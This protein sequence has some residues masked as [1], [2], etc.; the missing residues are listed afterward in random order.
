MH[1]TIECLRIIQ[2]IQSRHKEAFSSV[3]EP[4][5]MRDLLTPKQVAQA[6]GA[7]EAS[8]KR[9]CDKGLVPTLRTAG[10]HR[11]LPLDGVLQFLRES[12][13]PLVRPE[14]LGLPSA[15]GKG[16]F[17]LERAQA[18]LTSALVAGDE[19]QFSR[20]VFDLYVSGQT[21]AAIC[22]RAIAPAFAEIGERWD[23]G[24]VH[25]YEERR[26]CEVC[27]RV[28]HRLRAALPHPPPTAPSAIG[29]TLEADPYGIPTTTVELALLE[30]GWRAESLGS[31]LPV[32]T[33]E[34]ALE[35]MRPRLLWLSVAT[36]ASRDAILEQT[37]RL[38]GKASEL[39]AALVVGGRALSDDLRVQM[40]Y[41]A[42]CDT[43]QHLV[44]FARTL[45]AETKP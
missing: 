20:V 36:F 6:I 28:L 43:L 45:G 11:R 12:G 29:G 26:G 14:V 34:A 4:E 21:V 42:H 30:A 35:R 16:D 32:E 25:V 40:Q 18:L 10:G 17:T 23:H 3:G 7:S 39:G 5:A 33:L 22:D 8:L 9:W 19:E 27:L 15:T 31:G 38:F 2:N 44:A 1:R 13:H 24:T 41:T 37:S